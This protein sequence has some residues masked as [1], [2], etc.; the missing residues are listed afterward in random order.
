VFGSS[1]LLTSGQASAVV[2]GGMLDLDV[3]TVS[4]GDN[5]FLVAYSDVS[6]RGAMTATMG[7]VRGVLMAA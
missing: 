5:K 1:W 3:V 6:N 4:E 2:N 7:Q